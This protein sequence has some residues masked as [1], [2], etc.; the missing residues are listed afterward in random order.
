MRMKKPQTRIASVASAVGSVGPATYSRSVSSSICP[1]SIATRAEGH[2]VI[3]RIAVGSHGR[4]STP[5]A[6]TR[7]I[8]MMKCCQRARVTNVQTRTMRKCV[9]RTNGKGVMGVETQGVENDQ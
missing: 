8:Q 1:P 3:C 4:N 2:V 9:T 7:P 6:A 5:A